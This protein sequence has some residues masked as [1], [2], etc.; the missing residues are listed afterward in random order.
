[1]ALFRLHGRAEPS[2]SVLSGWHRFLSA[3]AYNKDM[4]VRP[5]YMPK[6]TR[7]FYTIE[8]YEFDWAPGQA[9]AQKKKN[10]QMLQSLWKE[11]HPDQTILEVSTKSDQENGV[12]L[13]PFNLSRRLPS[14]RKEFPVENIYQASKTF[15]HGGPY[16]DLLGV[17]PNKAVA[18]PRLRDSGELTSFRLEGVEYPTRPDFLFYTWLY[19]NALLENP[20]LAQI[21]KKTDAFCDIEFNPEKGT[22]NQAR[23][24][25]VFLSLS[26]LGLLDEVRDFESFKK[27]MMAQD[28]TEIKEQS[29]RPEGP[30]TVSQMRSE[31]RRQSFPVGAWI[32]HPTI[33]IGE[34]IRKTPTSYIIRFRVSGPKTLTKEFVET[35]CRRA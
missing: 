23:A 12:K 1:M 25:A 8:N 13:S 32:S 14:L 31:V 2:Q 16:V 17:T 3:G 11:K 21:V 35:A 27:I 4:S 22:N 34:V 18:D 20:G 26:R 5:V 30:Q 24:C 9:A 28:I 33:G 10:S 15:R 29:G 6:L 19:I 7:P